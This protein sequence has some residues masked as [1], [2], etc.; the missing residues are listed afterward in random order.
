MPSVSLFV[1]LGQK[2]EGMIQNSLD[3]QDLEK[4]KAHLETLNRK[5]LCEFMEAQAREC[6]AELEQMIQ[7]AE[8]SQALTTPLPRAIWAKAQETIGEEYFAALGKLKE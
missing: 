1:A 8:E 6:L 4:L 5:E 2:G 7:R 3:G